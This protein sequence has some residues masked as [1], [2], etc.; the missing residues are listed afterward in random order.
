MESDQWFFSAPQL[1]EDW[2][3][4]CSNGLKDT[5]TSRFEVKK[6][7]QAKNYQMA[8]VVASR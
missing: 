3:E 5:K 2:E 6:Q 7:K 4:R 1:G 8:F